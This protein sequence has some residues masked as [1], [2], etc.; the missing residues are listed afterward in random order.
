MVILHGHELTMA[1]SWD[2]GTSKGRGESRKARTM[3]CEHCEDEAVD[4]VDRRG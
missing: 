3:R 4:W 1:D 2:K